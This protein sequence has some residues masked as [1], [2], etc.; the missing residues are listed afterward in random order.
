MEAVIGSANFTRRNLDDYNLEASLW[1]Q[2]PRGSNLDREL[3][4]YM[5]RLWTNDEGTYTL[6]YDAFR[7]TSRLRRFFAWMQE[8]TGLG[9]F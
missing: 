9:T 7:D 2:A 5:D 3:K 1:V 4:L 6:P 8:V